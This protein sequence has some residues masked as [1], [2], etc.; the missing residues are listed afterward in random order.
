MVINMSAVRPALL[1]IYTGVLHFNKTNGQPGGG[2]IG[3]HVPVTT[4]SFPLALSYPSLSL[5]LSLSRF[6]F[7]VDGSGA[8]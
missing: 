7:P 8:L 5:S 6:L 3:N 2:R 1:A 4:F